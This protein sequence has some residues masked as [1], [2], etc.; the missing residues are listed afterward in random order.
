MLVL[1]PGPTLVYLTGLRFHLSERPVLFVFTSDSTPLVVLPELEKGKLANVDF[2]IRSY[3]YTEDLTTWE[4]AFRNVA[5][6]ARLDLRRVAIEPRR[7]RV[8]ELRMLENA[9]PRSAYISGDALIAAIR[10]IK[11]ADEIASMRRA[12]AIAQTAI[13]QTLPQLKI[14]MTELEAASELV[15]QL[16]RAGSDS[17]LPFPPIVAFGAHS[18]DPHAEPGK[19]KLAAGDAVLFDWGAAVDGYVS[20]ITRTY[21]FGA[22][23]EKLVGMA[24][25]VERANQAGFEAAATHPS[26]GEVDDAA[27]AVIEDAG[28]GPYFI[29]RTGHG[30]GLETHEEPYISSNNALHL[31]PGMTFTIE[32]GIYIPDFGGV[33][34]E[35]DVIVTQD[36]AD[37]LSDLP[38][39]LVR[40]GA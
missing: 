2:E 10:M 28:Y 5:A 18:A 40:L 29:H 38:R 22:P 7:L 20:D 12:V 19:R 30:L 21:S 8:L 36:G 4:R 17:A 6:D 39:E 27:R 1:N 34:I 14:G 33:R 23:D 3:T 15:L 37:C 31:L 32:P 9:A 25:I 26:A 16:L 11:D 13:R 24:R 35:D